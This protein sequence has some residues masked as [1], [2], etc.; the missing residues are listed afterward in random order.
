[1]TR[2]LRA[3]REFRLFRFWLTVTSCIVSALFVPSAQADSRKLPLFFVENR[4]QFPGTVR[5]VA[6]GAQL[7]GYFSPADVVMAAGPSRFRVTFPGADP[8][9]ALEGTQL[10]AARVNY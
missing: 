6:K 1:M 10:L 4:G 9:A 3:V 8:R 5:F 2:P 7:S